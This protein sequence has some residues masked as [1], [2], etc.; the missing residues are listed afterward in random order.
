MW[1]YGNPDTIIN[2]VHVVDYEHSTD[3]A[4]GRR[5]VT[6]IAEDGRRWTGDLLVGADGIRSKVC[7]K[8]S[9]ECLPCLLTKMVLTG[10]SRG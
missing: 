9:L 1:K 2:N 3:P 10:G 7:R 8:A 5:Q 6:A 4:T